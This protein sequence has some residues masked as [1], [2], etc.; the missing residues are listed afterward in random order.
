MGSSKTD[1]IEPGRVL[2]IV[3]VAAPTTAGGLERVVETLAVGLHRRGHHVTVVTL[4]FDSEATHPFVDMLTAEGVR[5]HTVRL[6]HRSYLKE[7]RE[8]ARLFRSIRPDVVHTHGYRIDLLD[9]QVAARLGIPTVTTVH[10]ASKTDGLKGKFFE[11]LQRRNYRRFDAVVA[12]S[13]PLRD[14][15]IA[16][17]VPAHRLHLVQNA[18]AGL[19]EPLS[20]EAA[21][22]Q[23]ALDEGSC[24]VGW[25]GR[26][27]PVKGGDVF[28]DALSRIPEPRPTGVMIGY[29]READRLRQQAEELGLARTVRFYPEIRDAARYYPAFD[30]FALSS[31]SEGLPIVILEAMAAGVPIVATRVGGVTDALGDQHAW[32]VPP[33]DPQALALAISDALRDRRSAEKRAHD[34]ARRLEE[35]YALDRFLDGYEQVYRGILRRAHG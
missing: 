24:V 23:L 3:Q 8:I 30:V 29:G 31:R 4:L 9:R 12:V 18:W 15:T 10:G 27:I 5:V 16:D 17:G 11:W 22:Q 13:T 32:L 34:A 2:S 6:G 25:V 1:P 35:H 20:R 7:R 33:E 26:F 14:A 21:R 19:R 28:L